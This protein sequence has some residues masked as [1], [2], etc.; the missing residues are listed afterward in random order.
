MA[1]LA[2]QDNQ[3]CGLDMRDRLSKEGQTPRSAWPL[4]VTNDDQC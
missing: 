3:P 1:F 2:L 4:E